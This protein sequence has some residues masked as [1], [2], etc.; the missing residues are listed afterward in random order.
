MFR[1]K[2]TL[3]LLLTMVI[4]GLI[5]IPASNSLM[6][7]MEIQASGLSWVTLVTWVIKVSKVHKVFK[8]HLVYSLV[9]HLSIHS[10]LQQPT[11][12]QVPVS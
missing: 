7:M 11:Q 10:L 3:Q 4:F 5:P 6:L 9:L 1:C 2:Q 8:A 12:I